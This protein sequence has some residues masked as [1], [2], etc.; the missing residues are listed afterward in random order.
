MARYCDYVHC[1]STYLFVRP[2]PTLLQ[3]LLCCATLLLCST[4]RTQPTPE[5]PPE[6]RR[7]DHVDVYHG[8]EVSDPYRWLEDLAQ[9]ETQQWMKAQDTYARSSLH[10]LVPQW[11]QIRSQLEDTATKMDRYTVPLKQ[12]EQYYYLHL[13][14][15]QLQPVLY[16]QKGLKGQPEVV[17]DPVSFDAEGS[18][19]LSDFIVS[20][21]GRYMAYQLAYSDAGVRRWKVRDLETGEDLAEQW[22]GIQLAKHPWRT[23]QQGFYYSRQDESAKLY[24]HQVG[25]VITSDR[26]IVERPDARLSGQVSADGRFLVITA[27]SEQERRYYYQDLSTDQDAIVAWFDASAASAHR[28]LGQHEQRFWFYT[29]LDA[30]KGRVVRIDLDEPALWTDVIPE[31]DEPL[32]EAFLIGNKLLTSYLVDG[33]PQLKI[34]DVEG[35][36]LHD[37]DTP[38]GLIWT[39][40]LAGWSG[41]SGS[42]GGGEAFFRSLSLTAPG[43]VFRVD[44]NT[45]ERSVFLKP[46]IDGEAIQTEDFVTQTVFYTSN[47]G[48]KVPMF[49]THKRGLQQDGSHPTLLNTFSALGFPDTPYFNPK[50][51]TFLQM[52]GLFA[53]PGA[54]GGGTY[55]EAWHQDGAQLNKQNSIDDVIAAA[56][57][58][59][60]QGYTVPEKLAL[61]GTGSGTVNAGAVLT[62]RPDLFAATT[63]RVPDTDMLRLSALIGR[64][65]AEWGSPEDKA[66]FEVLRS[67]SPYHNVKG[68]TCYPTT[69]ITTG[70]LDDTSPSGHANK[71]TAAL[72]HAQQCENPIFLRVDWGTGHGDR[73]SMPHRI[74]EWADELTLLAYALG[75]AL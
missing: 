32:D 60:D 58:L 28:Y 26:L 48:T 5:K 52:G 54:R 45:G 73:K 56:E 19:A 22:E 71:L 59:I 13:G 16:R 15:G 7:I 40:Y 35:Q 49:I 8:V 68:D 43:V 67:Y 30:P 33:R 62:Q 74:D 29:T 53:Y 57:W 17:I 63:L 66:F 27:R 31:A 51:F 18:V 36:F 72:Q 23:D 34:F 6:T 50:F 14:E 46:V 24:Y 2:M 42:P 39:D 25:T 55:G 1:N 20:P 65:R 9:E 10:T 75:M 41:I 47:D 11:E 64:T 70:D 38:V 3:A 12:G 44:M 69:L 21:D 61:E 37:V 4:C